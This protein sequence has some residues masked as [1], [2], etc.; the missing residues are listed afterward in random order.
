MWA[1]LGEG[2]RAAIMIRGLL[3]YNTLPNLFCNHPPFQ[4]DGNFG[5]PAAMAEMLMQ[6]HAGEIQLLP[7]VPKAWAAK[8]SFSGLR[9]RGG[10]EVDCSWKDGKVTNYKISSSKPTK[11]KLRVNGELKEIVTTVK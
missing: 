3:T 9:A 8:G 4:L 1:R 6:S 10:Y 5:I 2:E 7:A 11:V